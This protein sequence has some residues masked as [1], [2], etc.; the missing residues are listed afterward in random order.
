MPTIRYRG[1]ADHRIITS[2]QLLAE[3]ITSPTLVW[4]KANGFELDTDAFT[5]AYL[6]AT[7]QDFELGD[8]NETFMNVLTDL[9]ATPETILAI[10]NLE[11]E[12]ADITASVSRVKEG[13]VFANDFGAVAGT[14]TNQTT[15]IASAITFAVANGVSVVQ[16][17][18]G[19]YH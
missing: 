1:V 18:P 12:V 14:G 9:P 10:E 5:A 2:A 13:V 4:E 19:V 11:T 3:G 8:P 7:G 16:L 15:A 17:G 6:L